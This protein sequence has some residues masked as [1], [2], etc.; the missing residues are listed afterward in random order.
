M[1]FKHPLSESQ[2]ARFQHATND[3]EIRALCERAGCQVTG[4]QRVDGVETWYFDGRCKGTMALMKCDPNGEY[5]GHAS[6]V[7]KPHHWEC[8]IQVRSKPWWLPWF[9][10]DWGFR[11]ALA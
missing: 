7:L 5:Y 10:L 8:W 6:Q 1:L 9:V 4:E 2:Y 3:A 11:Q